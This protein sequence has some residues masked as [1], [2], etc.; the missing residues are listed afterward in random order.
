M[1]VSSR[2]E[3]ALNRKDFV[4]KNEDFK[5]IKDKISKNKIGVLLPLFQKED[6]VGIVFLGN[7]ISAKPFSSEDVYL[8][9]VLSYQVSI[10]I[11]NALLYEEI[12]KDKAVLEKFYKLTVGREVKMAELKEKIRELEGKDGNYR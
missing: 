1:F 2:S 8:L 10:S 3:K 6:L 4:A 11:N 5:I 7:K 9:E 12:K